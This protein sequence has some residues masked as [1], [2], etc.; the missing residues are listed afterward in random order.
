MIFSAKNSLIR[1]YAVA[2]LLFPFKDLKSQQVYDII[3]VK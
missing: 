2:P 1:E 3:I